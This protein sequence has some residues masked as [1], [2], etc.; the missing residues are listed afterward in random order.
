MKT[1]SYARASDVL[2]VLKGEEKLHRAKQL[3]DDRTLL[4][5]T[6]S[7][8]V[9]VRFLNASLGLKLDRVP[10]ELEGEVRSAASAHNLPLI[11]AVMTGSAR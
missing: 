9:G 7:E 6:G 2:Y 3:D 8:P 5:G 4:Y 11:E 10:S 1:P